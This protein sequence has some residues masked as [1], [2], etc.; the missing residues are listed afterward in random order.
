MNL[1]LSMIQYA[2]IQLG[3]IKKSPLHP[4]IIQV[5]FLEATTCLLFIMLLKI[6]VNVCGN[7]YVYMDSPRV[8]S[9]SM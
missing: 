7:T 6:S 3:N 9:D 5:P 4:C 2:E 8:T 1:D